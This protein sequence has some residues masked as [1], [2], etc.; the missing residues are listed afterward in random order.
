MLKSYCLGYCENSTEDLI[1]NKCLAMIRMS[2]T[3][4]IA[5]AWRALSVDPFTQCHHR[6]ALLTR[7]GVIE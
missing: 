6:G 4:G 1:H 5:L 2:T 3:V 7:A